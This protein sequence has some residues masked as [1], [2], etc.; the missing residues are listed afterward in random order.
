MA[1]RVL[2]TGAD[3][4]WGGRM[5]QA[6]ETD[7]NLEMILGMGSH[8]PSVPF[9]RAE[10][11]RA[12]QNYS[13]VNRIVKA[14]QVDTILHTFMVT[15]SD[16]I[17]NR[18]V[19][20]I[21][22]IGTMNLLA[23]A[24]AAGSS[25]RHIV[26]KSST[27][28]YGSSARDPNTFA[29][30]TPRSGPAIHSI[31]RVL[32]EAE[33][34]V[35]DFS[36]DN[37]GTLV[38]V[39]RFANVLGPHLSTTLS[40]SLSRPVC[41][42]IFGFDPLLQFVEEDDVVRALLHVT[43]G[44]VPGLYNVA[45][46]GRLPWSEVAGI[47][48]TRLVPLSPYSPLKIHPLVR[49]FDLPPE[50][51]DLLRYGRGVDTRRFAATGFTYGATSAGAVQ[52]F[53]RRQEAAAGGGE[54]PD[55]VHLRVRRRAVL[56]ALTLG[57][58][59][60]RDLSAPEEAARLPGQPLRRQ[61]GLTHRP[62]LGRDGVPHVV[63]PHAVD[64]QEPLRDPLLPDTELLDH[65]AAGRVARDDRDLHPVQ[66][67]GVE[68]E[69][70]GH[71]DRFGREA[72]ARQCLVDPVA[73]EGALERPALNGRER[74][75]PGEP[76]ADEDAEA[77]PAPQVPFPLAYAAARREAGPVL[78]RH[79]C[80][81]GTGLPAQQPRAAPRPHLVPLVEVALGQWAERDPLPVEL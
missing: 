50:L 25:V 49:L 43:R 11:V 70:Q 68:G 63:L 33:S 5:I 72:A 16:G 48:G 54:D 42:S 51:E 29:E 38:T 76:V 21:N 4:F 6:L 23:A 19:H 41:P 14:T 20:E 52:S 46:E 2:V 26:V 62:L 31:E 36:E 27:L 7:P 28:V 35:R 67:N 74:H 59:P 32:L 56:P 3:T 1:R 17:S 69:L 9:E 66:R 37:P 75:L 22:V 58:R 65:P 10:F 30:D 53:I 45:G 78:G 39:L 13:I 81:L 73:D 64:L 61:L 44:G 47:C 40:R 79:G 77:V 60:R 57:D 55:V 8:V 34:L 80:P 12:D 15:N 18:R 24:G 71:H